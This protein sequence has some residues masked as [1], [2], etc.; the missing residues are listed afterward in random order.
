[1]KLLR[2]SLAFVALLAS[3]TGVIAAAAPV[4][5]AAP[6]WAPAAT[7]TIHPGVQTIT[8]GGQC[9][10]NFIFYDATDVY[11]G[12]AAHCSGTGGQTATNGCESGS[13]PLGTEVEVMGAS[14]PGV[15]VYS[16]WLTMEANGE[17]DP[18]ACQYN[19]FALVR[20]HPADAANVNPS[21][22]F[23]GGPVGIDNDGTAVGDLVFSYGN[24]SLRFG[25][26]LLSPKRGVSAGDAGA[27]WSH[28]VVTVTPGI[29]GDSGSAFLDA[30]GR[31][32]GV[33]STLQIAPLAG[34]NGVGDLARELAYL[35]TN[36]AF[37]VQ[38]ALGTE[39]FNG[40]RL[41]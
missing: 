38:L 33:L 14:N 17:T 15:L 4:A 23:F 29:H 40:S 2:R 39:P 18:N 34:F 22:P 16:S 24:S 9:T 20:L 8:A 32:L 37:A 1:M 41:I 31:A 12:Q 5:G 25:V 26:T 27:G 7:A 3:T 13:L 6:T 21:I 28:N 36:T 30:T 10:A 35:N 11:I 19:D